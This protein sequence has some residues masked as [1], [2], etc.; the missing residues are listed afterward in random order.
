MLNTLT[1]D[2][3]ADD[4]SDHSGKPW[5]ELNFEEPG[6]H[7]TDQGLEM[8]SAWSFPI[9]STLSVGISCPT[10]PNTSGAHGPDDVDF[11]AELELAYLDE[12]YLEGDSSSLAHDAATHALA[13][14]H[15]AHGTGKAAVQ[16]TGVVIS[17]VPSEEA[18]GNYQLT[19]YFLDHLA[20]LLI[21]EEEENADFVDEPSAA[22]LLPLNPP[23]LTPGKTVQGPATKVFSPAVL[24]F[25]MGA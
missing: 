3:A 10:Q 19:I 7:L 22:G 1:S 25:F 8:T 15:H 5:L 17:C 14:T 11:T 18:E 2:S 6:L 13:Q 4:L 16:A 20:N 24:P 9:G 21:L 12:P 23:K